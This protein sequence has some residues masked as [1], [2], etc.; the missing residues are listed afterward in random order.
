MVNVIFRLT[1][2]NNKRLGQWNSA[3]EARRDLV[4]LV[5]NNDARKLTYSI[6][7]RSALGTKVLFTISGDD[8][9]SYIFQDD[10]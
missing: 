8:L 4:D 3:E 5:A 6:T 10:E 7:K 9:I 2:D 1:D